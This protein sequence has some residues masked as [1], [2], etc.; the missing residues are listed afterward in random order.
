MNSLSA[1]LNR[2]D[3]TCA[4]PVMA[5]KLRGLI[6]GYDARWGHL[7]YAVTGIEQTVSSDLWNPAT[8]AKSRSFRVTGKLDLTLIEDGEPV[9]MDHKTTS[10][11][12]A[13]PDCAYRRQLIVEGQLSHY[14]LLEW[15]NG[16]KV[17]AA[18]WDVVKK[19]G[20]SPKQITKADQRALYDTHAYFGFAVSDDDLAAV[21]EFG[22]ETPT[23]Y[24]YRLA[25]DCTNSRPQE[26]FQRW[27][28]PRLDSEIL[29]YAGELWDHG[30]EILQAR[31]FNR[32]TRNS[33]ACLLYG[34]PCRF[35]GICSG[36][37]EPNSSN[38]KRKQF[39]HPELPPDGGDGRDLLTNSRIRCFQTCRRKHY[40]DYELGIERVES[41]DREAL[42]FGSLFHEALA[43]Y[44]EGFRKATNG[45]ANSNAVPV[46]EA[47]IGCATQD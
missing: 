2:I 16:R 31:R 26:Y 28:V 38:W 32:W 13:D 24:E 12:I 43:A 4:D 47:G 11:S 14:E 3:A 21:A 44:F 8:Q 45:N 17:R 22:R 20:I 36:H 30:Q 46:N 40:Y 23:L 37:D 7:D 29:E 33:G 34:S 5:A 41:E 10:E 39:V 25:D 1:A 42:V 19:P 15:L 6:R 27:R 18:V 9:L 35:L